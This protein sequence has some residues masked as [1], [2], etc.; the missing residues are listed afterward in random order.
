MNEKRASDG[1]GWSDAWVDMQRR[2]WDAWS[3]LAGQMPGMKPEKAP[4]PF[5][6]PWSQSFDFWSKLMAPTMPQ[7]SHSWMEKLLDLNKGY[8]QMGET[9]F[10][11]LSTSKETAKDG[12]QWW[13]TLGQ[14]VLKMHEKMA[15]G[16][17]GAKDPWGGFATL[18][19]L[20]LDSWKRVSSA[21]S[22]MPGDMEKAFRDIGASQG[23]GFPSM[24]G[25]WLSTPTLGYTRESQEEAQRLG[26]L[27]LEHARAVQGYAAVLSRVVARAGELLREKVLERM[28]KGETLDSVRASYDLWVDCGEDAYAEI[29][30]SEEFTKAQAELTNS[31]M[32]LKRQEQ[33][34]I[35]EMLGAMNMPTRRELDTSHRRVHELQ[36]RLWRMEQALDEAGVRELREEV[37]ALQRQVGELTRTVGQAS[38]ASSAPA[39]R[40][41]K[42]KN[43]T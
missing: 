26:Q 2:Y 12:G 1:A 39:R 10:R 25:D 38:A 9:L 30:C 3:D 28:G 7:E 19:G 43:V 23:A 5:A 34:M 8:L 13:E 11:T 41:T 15:A 37:A 33:K 32:A 24:V 22:M 42:L 4:E 40:S 18:W 36:R 27:W 6:N 20:P 31:L 35:D 17:T 29:S 14:S 16:F 21:C